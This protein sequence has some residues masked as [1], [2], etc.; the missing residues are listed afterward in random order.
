MRGHTSRIRPHHRTTPVLRCLGRRHFHGP[1]AQQGNPVD[2][3]RVLCILNLRPES[4]PLRC[5]PDCGGTG[6]RHSVASACC[7]LHAANAPPHCT[8]PPSDQPPPEAVSP[9]P[10]VPAL[11]TL[12]P[13]YAVC[14]KAA[15]PVTSR[16]AAPH[17]GHPARPEAARYEAPRSRFGLQ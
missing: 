3:R 9:P 17:R 4:R 13:H 14:S 15:R 12:Q 2:A 16:T 6:H 7:V 10:D 11:A 5:V 8:A 1:S